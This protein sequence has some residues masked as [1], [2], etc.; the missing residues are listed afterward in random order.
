LQARNSDESFA[1]GWLSCF[2]PRCPALPSSPGASLG[3]AACL[4]LKAI[5]LVARSSDEFSSS[6]GGLILAVPF[7]VSVLGLGHM[8][9]TG[10]GVVHRD[11]QT[12]WTWF[13]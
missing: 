10:D 7:N 5:F 4:F 2:C 12:N 6:P 8:R 11:L 9:A 3:F 13:R 1:G